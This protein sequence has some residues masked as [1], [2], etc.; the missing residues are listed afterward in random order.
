MEFEVEEENDF[1]ASNAFRVFLQELDNFYSILCRHEYSSDINIV[2]NL[3][4]R[5]EEFRECL[6]ILHRIALT[7]PS[8][9]SV[10]A[11]IEVIEQLLANIQDKMSTFIT[12][13]DRAEEERFSTLLPDLSSTVLRQRRAS[14][15]G[16]RPFIF[17]SR[18]QLEAFIELG[19]SFK[20]IA[21]MLCV[22]DRTLLRRRTELGLPVGRHLLYSTMDDDELDGIVSEILQAS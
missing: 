18:T 6:V 7:L 16:G 21:K 12:L 22:S 15:Q 17:I 13:L 20:A 19:F 5:A 11:L 14:T 8:H 3:A 2:E 4:F 1:F 10:E 9:P